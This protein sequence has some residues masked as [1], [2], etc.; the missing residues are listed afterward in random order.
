M[1]STIFSPF[2]FFVRSYKH[3]PKIAIMDDN[4]EEKITDIKKKTE[5]ER[6]EKKKTE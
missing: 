2:F 4:S 5:D 3:V 1:T 6:K